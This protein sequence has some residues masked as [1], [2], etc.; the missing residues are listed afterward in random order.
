M[1]SASLVFFC[2]NEYTRTYYLKKKAMTDQIETFDDLVN[3]RQYFRVVDNVSIEIAKIDEQHLAAEQFVDCID[4][5]ENS[6]EPLQGTFWDGF[7]VLG[8]KMTEYCVIRQGN[9]FK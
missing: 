8:C 9:S 6:K 5:S 3:R 1:Y 4:E 7:R 2:F